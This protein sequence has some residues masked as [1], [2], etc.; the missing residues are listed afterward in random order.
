MSTLSLPLPQG[1]STLHDIDVFRY[2]VAEISDNL[3]GDKRLIVLI[4][5]VLQ[6]I[7]A[8]R[9]YNKTYN[10][11]G[12][13]TVYICRNILSVNTLRH[14]GVPTSPARLSDI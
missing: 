6:Q 7:I 1:F 10:L 3:A 8:A 12:I 11:A 9:S 13:G 5:S 2:S 14:I 4:I